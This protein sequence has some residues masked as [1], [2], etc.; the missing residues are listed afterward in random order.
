MSRTPEGVQ[1]VCEKK[2]VRIFR[3]LNFTFSNPD[4]FHADFLHMGETNIGRGEK[5]PT[6][7][8]S[9]LLRKRS[10][11]LRANFVLTKDRKQPYYR[12]FCVQIHREGSCSKAAGGPYCGVQNYSVSGFIIF[13]LFTVIFCQDWA[14]WGVFTVIPGNPRRT[15]GD[16]QHLEARP[17][18]QDWL[19]SELF[20]VKNSRTGPFSNHLVQKKNSNSTVVIRNENS[21]Q[22]GSFWPDIPADIRPKTSV[23]PSKSWKNKHSGTD[24]PRGHP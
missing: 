2:F 20:T 22:K 7:K 10:V 1:E 12:H 3:S 21:A 23:R 16:S 5:T 19:R 15:K 24:I 13:E 17:E 11:L 18:L 14:G 6:P 8:I 9:A 4:S